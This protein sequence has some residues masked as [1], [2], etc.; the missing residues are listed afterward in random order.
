[1]ISIKG[2]DI[3]PWILIVPGLFL[4]NIFPRI[5]FEYYAG[6]ILGLGIILFVNG[7]VLLNKE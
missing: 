7:A 1:M 5:F 3:T 4:I 6:L 2:H